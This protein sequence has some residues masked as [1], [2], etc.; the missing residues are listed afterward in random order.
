MQTLMKEGKTTLLLAVVFI[1]GVV[2]GSGIGIVYGGLTSQVHQSQKASDCENQLS[3]IRDS[4]L[5][6]VREYNKL[7]ALKSAPAAVGQPSGT[8]LPMPAITSPSPT[9]KA[10]ATP[11]TAPS[12]APSSGGAAT[13]T[14]TAEECEC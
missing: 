10:A 7:L 2:T 4:Y 14:P 12:A 6:L 3:T 9:P 8:A 1:F 5:I 13:P 11:T